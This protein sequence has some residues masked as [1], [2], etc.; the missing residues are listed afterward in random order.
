PIADIERL[1]AQSDRLV[2][3]DDA[4]VDFAPDNGLRLLSRYPNFLLLRTL[5]KSYAAASIRVRFG[6]GHPQL[7]GR[8]R[9]IQNVC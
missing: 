4:Y 1:L 9:N 2:V 7:I 8:L 3:L 5:S 6:F